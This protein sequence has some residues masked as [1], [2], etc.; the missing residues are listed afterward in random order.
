LATKGKRDF[1]EILGVERNATPDQ[2]K[3]AFRNRARNLHPDNMDSGDEAAFKELA[4]AYEVLSDESKRSL[5]DRYGH[6]GLSGGAGGF[7]GVD[8]GGFADLSEIFAQF[9][10]G[11]PRGGSGARRNP[12]ERGADLKYD[13]SLDF[14]EAVFGVEKKISIKHMQDCT[15]CSGSGAAQ[16]SS[17]V[18]C[19]TCGGA[20]QIRQTTSTFLGHF[21]QVLTCPNCEGEGTRVEKPCSNC[22]GR[23][24][25]RK[26]R[27]IE[28]KIPP[29]IDSGARMRVPG[30]GDQGRHNGPPGDLYVILHVGEHPN[31][32][33]EGTTIHL[34]QPVS[35]SMAALGGEL[36]IP[37][38][39]GVK[40]LRIPAGIQTGSTLVMRDHG[41]PHLN[42]PSKRG[43]QLVHVV[44]ETPTRLSGEEKK[45]FEKLA[46]LRKE[47]LQVPKSQKV[48]E[49]GKE[50]ES[51]IDKIVDVF[52]PKDGDE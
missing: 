38:V 14:L 2:I 43:D 19:S 41:V 31:F 13:L 39:E 22:K 29:G 26:S 46:E 32:M 21:T 24:Q 11:S 52:R 50:G 6:D 45:L 25:I 12:V 40:A 17:R 37:T 28:L 23:G 36:M 47:K 48:E 7:D 10:G 3:K 1:Y 34:R 42:N 35:F 33:R 4:A 44:V 30:M 49:D 27:D 20:G 9:F 15:A 5:Y 18:Q 51:I 8:L 16:G